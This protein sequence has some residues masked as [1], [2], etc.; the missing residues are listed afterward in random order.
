MAEYTISEFCELPSKG[1]IY[2]KV[3]N[4]NIRLRSMTTEEEMRRLSP[5]DYPYKTLC[6]IIDTCMVEPCGISTYDMCLGDY[7][8]LLH[9][10][11]IITYGSD[12]PSS[13]ICPI[14]GKVNRVVLNLDE[15][16]VLEF[17]EEEIKGL[18]EFE[19][20]VSKKKI[21]LKYQTPRDIDEIEK[22]EK[23]FKLK[24]PESTINIGYLISLKHTIDT[25]DG[26]KVEE[27][28]LEH[29]L[30]NLPMRD[31]NILLQKAS[32]I[33]EKVG[34]DTRI[35]NKCTNPKCGATYQTTFRITN[36]FFGPTID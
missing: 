19:L 26:K 17:K 31:T 7:Q 29:F 36:E 21:K 5:T 14:C 1:K 9:Q 13:S 28:K 33:N 27:Y 20:P 15:I 25:I 8:Y 18:M 35:N 30:R 16:K 12:Y 22:E 23:E 34:I 2:N 24:N 4:P 6:D 10:L 11:R 32:K 3:I